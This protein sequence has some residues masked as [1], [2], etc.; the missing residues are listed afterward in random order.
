[1]QKHRAPEFCLDLEIECNFN[2]R[3]RES[4]GFVNVGAVVA[5]ALVLDR[6]HIDDEAS[7]LSL[8]EYGNRL[9]LNASSVMFG[10]LKLLHTFKNCFR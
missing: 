8:R 9:S 5:M 6:P 2:R 10:Y 4:Q 1:M 3:L 7:A